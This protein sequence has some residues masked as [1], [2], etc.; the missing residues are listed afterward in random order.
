M[1][2]AFTTFVLFFVCA[3]ALFFVSCGKAGLPGADGAD[4]SAYIAYSWAVGPITFY[5]EDPA[6]SGLGYITN[7]NYLLAALGTFYFEYIAWDD[8]YW[9][10]TYTIYINEGEPGLPGEPSTLFQ[11]GA[12]GSDGADGE[13]IYLELA[14]YSTGPTLWK[15]S[16]EYRGLNESSNFIKEIQ[17]AHAASLYKPAGE[18]GYIENSAKTG[19]SW[20][21][22][23]SMNGCK[24]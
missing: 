14:C 23:P 11:N 21:M 16:Y 15:W 19:P 13:D 8:S 9:V 6:F 12:D 17:A 4:G 5:T 3:A 24:C 22:L 20:M 7:G 10:G 2:K 1:S 18:I